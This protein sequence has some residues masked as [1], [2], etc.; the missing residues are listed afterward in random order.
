MGPAVPAPGLVLVL[1][2]GLDVLVVPSGTGIG[3]L[4]AMEQR[5][6]GLEDLPDPSLLFGRPGK[7]QKGAH[8]PPLHVATCYS[9][10]RLWGSE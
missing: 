3:A 7:A 1:H 4:P 2:C 9:S 8:V 6:G 10:T 5:E